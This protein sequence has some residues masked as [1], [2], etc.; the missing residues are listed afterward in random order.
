MSHPFPV[1]LLFLCLAALPTCAPLQSE[2]QVPDTLVAT[3]PTPRRDGEDLPARPTQRVARA[4]AA[5][6]DWMYHPSSA[7]GHGSLALRA[8]NRTQAAHY[9]A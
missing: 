6:Q 8:V 3:E 7:T 9:G 1:R 4:A 2:S 5:E